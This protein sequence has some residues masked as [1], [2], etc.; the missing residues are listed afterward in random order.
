MH[1]SHTHNHGHGNNQGHV[2]HSGCSH[3][4]QQH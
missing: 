2:H 1:S 3:G 4:Q